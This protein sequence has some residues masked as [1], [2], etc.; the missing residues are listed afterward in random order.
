MIN[1]IKKIAKVKYFPKFIV[2]IY[3]FT[4]KLLKE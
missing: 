2:V 3:A 4:G 1:L